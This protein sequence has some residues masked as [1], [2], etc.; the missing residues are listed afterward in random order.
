[1]K[2]KEFASEILSFGTSMALYSSIVDGKIDE[3][4]VTNSVNAAKVLASLYDELPDMGGLAGMIFG[5]KKKLSEFGEELVPFATAMLSYSTIISGVNSDII[6]QTANAAGALVSLENEL[7]GEEGLISLFSRQEGLDDFGDKLKKFGQGLLSYYESVKTIDTVKLV[8]VITQVQKL[9]EIAK[10][11]VGLDTSGL[12]TFASD[13]KTMGNNGITE[14]LSAFN[15]ALDR[16]TLTVQ[17]FVGYVLLAFTS[18][19]ELFRES[20]S[21]SADYWLFGISARSKEAQ[22]TGKAM[23]NEFISAIKNRYESMRLTGNTS[24][25]RYLSGIKEKYE[26]ATVTGT[27]IANKV[28]NAIVLM[29][30]DFYSTGMTSAKKIVEGFETLLSHSNEKS[31]YKVGQN[32]GQGFIDGVLS[33][34]AAAASAGRTLA[35]SMTNAA[36]STLQSHSPSRVMAQLGEYAGIGFINGLMY[37]VSTASMA[38]EELAGAAVDG[39]QFVIQDLSDV[40]DENG[41]VIRPTVDLTDVE[42]SVSYINSLFNESI[43]TLAWTANEAASLIPVKPIVSEKIGETSEQSN[44]PKNQYTFI[45]N[46]NSPKALSRID[47]YRQTKNQFAQF[48]KVVD[49]L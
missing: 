32:A 47:L 48:K 7:G 22:S 41:P 33:K 19:L 49:Q 1:M 30:V 18:Q 15:E 35:T 38:G 8:T 42:N 12:T 13:L 9:I 43:Q 17:A 24:A 2:F 37:C 20:G 28:K 46:N 34:S 6:T 10:S 11:V 39:L 23:A 25:N 27:S 14:F 40:F 44:S 31:F 26:S 36:S 3:D 21:T 5:D 29:N 45:Q 16:I 4:A